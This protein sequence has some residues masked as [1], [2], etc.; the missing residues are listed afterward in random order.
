MN[1]PNKNPKNIISKNYINTLSIETQKIILSIGKSIILVII[2]LLLVY[3]IYYIYKYYS[4][5]CKNKIPL[6]KYLT[7]IGNQ[8]ICYIPMDNISPVEE[9]IDIIDNN[10]KSNS[11]EVFQISNQ[12]YT[13]DEAKCK[14][15]SYGSRLATKAELTQ[16]YNNGAHW[17][18]YGWI[19]GNDAYYP[20]Q[21]CELDKKAI[22]IKNY[23]DILKKHYEEPNKYTLKM[24]NDA[25]QK[26]HRENS[27]EF[28]GNSSGLNGGTFE[29]KNVRFGATCF[30]KKPDGISIRE[31]EA[32]CKDN[33]IIE[34]SEQINKENERKAT[35][36][37]VSKNDIIVSFNYD[38]W[39]N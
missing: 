3:L 14:C 20:V 21:Q 34:E 23:N 1:I 35:C 7:N 36:G 26:M 6:Y 9:T 25:R 38:K 13:Y 28:C 39:N 4:I 37:G 29:D 15:E 33:N 22:N 11:D 18:N 12:L 8:Y 27:L 5:Q 32:K 30:G 2:I 19:D 17:C 24:V 31:K 10:I 16:A